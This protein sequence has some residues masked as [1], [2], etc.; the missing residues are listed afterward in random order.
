MEVWL[1][2]ARSHLKRSD[3]PDRGSKQVAMIRIVSTTWQQ[4]FLSLWF[5]IIAFMQHKSNKSN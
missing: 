3:G 5:I 4:E 1:A 2:T